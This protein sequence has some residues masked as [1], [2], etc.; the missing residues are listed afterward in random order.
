[1]AGDY[2]PTPHA[3]GA[4]EFSRRI[5]NR[6]IGYS[7]IG[8]LRKLIMKVVGYG[9]CSTSTPGV[10]V[11]GTVATIGAIHILSTRARHSA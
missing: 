11:L 1:M 3:P 6:S 7:D 10:P 9:G 8:S 4:P 2:L 5:I